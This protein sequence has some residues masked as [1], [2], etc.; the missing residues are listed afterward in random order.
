MPKYILIAGANGSGKSTLFHLLPEFQK[1][2]RINTDEIVRELGDWKNPDD[3]MRA[4]RIAVERLNQ[5]LSDKATF[6][7]ETTLC[8]KTIL[9]NIQTAK[10]EGYYI[11]VHYVGV[12]TVEVAKERIAIR[13]QHGG[14]GV[15]EQDVERR[16]VESL[17]NLK[18]IL[19]QC[20]LTVFYD[21]TEAFHRFAIYKQ[22]K[23]IKLSQDIPEWFE[24]NIL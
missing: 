24:K 12:E 8:G 15:P 9:K 14:H 4:G 1:M 18:I 20:D 17:K 3:V 23:L 19:S 21:N 7:Q 6:N 11:E 13:V 10:E 5:L 2:P 16:Y 22:G